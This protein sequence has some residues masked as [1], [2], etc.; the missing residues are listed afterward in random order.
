MNKLTVFYCSIFIIFS[1]L[2]IHCIT[3][4]YI[5]HQKGNIDKRAESYIKVEDFWTRLLICCWVNPAIFTLL[6][7]IITSPEVRDKE[8]LVS[9]N[10][11]GAQQK[12]AGVLITH[13]SLSHCSLPDCS[14]SPNTHTSPNPAQYWCISQHCLSMDKE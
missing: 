7:V 12:W 3:V 13:L 9:R 6:I 4:A 5:N 14:P 2:K 10:D 11:T 1:L 8:I